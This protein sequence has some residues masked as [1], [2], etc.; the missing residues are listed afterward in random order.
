MVTL[1]TGTHM[2]DLLEVTNVV[3]GR[4]V[5]VG[6]GSIGMRHRSVLDRLGLEVA[7]ISRRPGVGDFVDEATA[8]SQFEPNYAVV[9]TEAH[10]HEAALQRLAIAGHRGR[11]LVEKPVF[12]Q[13][14]SNPPSC[15]EWLGVGYNLRFH[16]AT[17]ALRNALSGERVLSI[18]ARVGQHLS[19]WRPDRNYRETVTAGPSGG[20]LLELSHELDLVAWLVGPTAVKGGWAVRTG[21]LDIDLDDLAVCVLCFG[22]QGLASLELNLLDRFPTRQMVVTTNLATYELDLN[23]GSLKRS[24]ELLFQES[25]DRDATFA[26]MHQAA[27]SDGQGVCTLSEAVSV[28]EQIAELRHGG[29]DG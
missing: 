11:V 12:D 24:G 23:G 28:V 1:W 19:E 5:V 26:A 6:A 27:L 13:P 22:N 2:T 10:D 25:V 3:S 7:V 17:V 9:A 14:E 21:Q 18:Q 8:V 29:T 15:F 16:P 20:A 4:A